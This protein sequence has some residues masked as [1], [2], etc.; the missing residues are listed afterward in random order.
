MGGAPTRAGYT[1]LRWDTSSSGNG[2]QYAA[3]EVYRANAGLTL[4][5]IWKAKT[6]TITFNVNGGSGGPGSQTKTHGTG[7]YLSSTKPS[8]TG[9][10]FSKWTTQQNGGG[11]SYS[12]GDWYTRE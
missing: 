2:N 8:R 6:Y 10:D 3:G 12:P 5:A 1:F 7:I 9:Y 4:Y 11:T